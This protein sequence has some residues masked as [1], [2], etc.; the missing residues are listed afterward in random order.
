MAILSL[1][2][3][4]S[5]TLAL[6][7][8]CLILVYIWFK[9]KFTYWAK[10]GVFG[11]TPVFP[12]GNIQNV[13]KRKVQFFEPYCEYYFKYKHLPYVGMYCFNQPVLSI[14]DPD[15]AKLVLIKDYEHFQSHG[16]FSG[17][18]GDP[19]AG[20]LF[21]I[22]GNTWKILRNK[23]SPTFT[24]AKLKGMYPLVE[25]IAKESLL[26]ADNIHSASEVINISEFYEKYTMEIIGSVGFGVECN[27]FKNSQ[28]EFYLRGHEY[29]E[30]TSIYWFV[31]YYNFVFM[32]CIVFFY[33]ILRI[34]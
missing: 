4:S 33:L 14:N 32:N 17:G 21:N 25:K 9:Y 3:F 20:H 18:Y 2:I 7:V 12:Y 27:G 24:A 28:S 29:F 5:E 23:M 1:K 13:I 26:Y 19:L 11:P 6:A 15:L 16:I 8:V 10:K 34:K 22:H 31:Y 30:P